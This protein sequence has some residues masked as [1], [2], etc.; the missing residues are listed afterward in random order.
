MSGR[1]DRRELLVR[2]GLVAGAGAAGLLAGTQLDGEGAPA[3]GVDAR[4]FTLAPDDVNLTTFVL[5]S[6]PRVVRDAIERH[7]RALDSERGASISASPS[8]RSRRRRGA[9]PPPTSGLEPGPGRAHRLDDDGARPRLRAPA[10][11]ARRRGRDD[12]ARLLRHARVAPPARASATARPSAGSGSTTSRRRPRS[13]EIV[14]AV[15]RGLA[16]ADALPRDH[17]GALVERREAAAARDRRRGRRR[18]PRP[19]RGA[20]ASSSASTASTASASRTPRP[21]SSASTSSSPAATSGSSARAAPASSGRR[22][23][24]GSACPDDP[25]L[26]R[27]RRT[28]PGSSV[29]R[30]PDAPPGPADDARAA[31]TRSSTAGR[32]PRRSSSTPSSAAARSRRRRTRSRR[33]LKQGLAEIAQRHAEDP[34]GR[35]P[36]RRP[37]LRR[38]RGRPDPGEVVD[39]LRE[40]HRVVASVTPYATGT[41]AS[42]RAS[43]NTEDDVD[44]ASRRC[45]QSRAAEPTVVAQFEIRASPNGAERPGGVPRLP[46]WPGMR[47]TLSRCR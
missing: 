18:E 6:H 9:P 31:S 30:R 20:S 26:R 12:R 44:R 37:R 40:E 38:R 25:D 5:A 1:F 2:G 46:A 7:R 17:L 43:P 4:Q 24:P 35:G 23:T 42:G 21:W 15:A 28:S 8:R 29:G 10:A 13:D 19:R 39:L 45:R 3:A 36:L 41:C 16:P 22:R 27:P 34:D 33:R 32:S 47:S 11:R 14:A